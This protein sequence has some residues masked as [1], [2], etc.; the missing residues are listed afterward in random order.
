MSRHD[1]IRAVH[2][3]LRQMGFR[4]GTQ[5]LLPFALAS[6]A[7][8][9]SKPYPA[10]GD[11]PGAAARS[12]PAAADDGSARAHSDTTTRATAS[13]HARSA[14]EC[15]LIAPAMA[16]I[17]GASSIGRCRDPTAQRPAGARMMSVAARSA[18][19]SGEF[20]RPEGKR[21]PHLRRV[22]RREQFAD[23]LRPEPCPSPLRSRHFRA[24]AASCHRSREVIS[25][26]GV[27]SCLWWLMKRRASLG[28]RV[29]RPG[30]TAADGGKGRRRQ[31]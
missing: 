29:I 19:F 11:A 9:G 15:A 10:A 2:N 27:F 7:C 25:G 13:A 18:F 22:R 23:A 24:R 6:Y 17:P 1:L 4:R 31:A 8:S 26:A 3:R 12:G 28:E 16:L 20:V 21:L 30:S 5:S 14:A